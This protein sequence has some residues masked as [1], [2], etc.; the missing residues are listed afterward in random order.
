MRMTAALLATGV[1]MSSLLVAQSTQAQ[2]ENLTFDVVSVKPNKSGVGSTR[3]GRQPGGRWIMVNMAASGLI[4]SAYPTKVS[5]LVG[6]PD[7]VTAERFDVEAR[8]TF[9]PTPGQEDMMLRALLADRFKLAA[10]YQTQE[11]P[12]YKLVVA[13][14]DGRL[15]PHLRRI[16]ID[17][18][19]Y[20]P[21]PRAPSATPSSVSDA[22]ICGYRMSG[23]K[24]LSIVS[25]GRTMQSLADSISH[26]AGR[27]IFDKTGLTGY[28]AYKLESIGGNDDLSIF[29]ALQEQLG[30]KLEPAR[31]PVDVVVID[32][33]ERPTEN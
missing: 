22:P 8:A 3:I 15:G 25:G 4:L 19:T 10:H 17:C 13:R 30:L 32:H 33:I 6:A 7:W 2:Q 14:A 29:T 24:T 16:D 27:P 1:L 18:A 21:Q 31:G 28:Y 23:G 20:K 11:R 26:L 12:I 5:E 9:E